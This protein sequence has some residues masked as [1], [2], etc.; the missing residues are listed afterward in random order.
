MAND[1]F[2]YSCRKYKPAEVKV[3]MSSASRPCCSR[4]RDMIVRRAA[5]P[6]RKR[7]DAK[8]QRADQ[9]LLKRL[10]RQGAI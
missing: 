1:F 9:Y 8:V 5:T 10:T 4:C 6:A 3:H 7:D 2:C